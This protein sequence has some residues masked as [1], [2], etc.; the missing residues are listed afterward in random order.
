MAVPQKG[1]LVNF[2]RLL[3][4]VFVVGV[5]ATVVF[6]AYDLF[7]GP[8]RIDLA[9]K[10]LADIIESGLIVP[11][12]AIGL[13]LIFAVFGMIPFVRQA[14]PDEIKGGV[15]ATATI[16]ELWDTG[17][18]WNKNPQVGFLLEVYPQEGTPFQ[19]KTKQVVS[20]LN[21]GHIGPGG[22]V[23]VKYDP[24]KPQRLKILQFS[25]H[26]STAQAPAANHSAARLTELSELLAQGLITENEFNQ[27]RQEILRNL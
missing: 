8:G 11:L 12:L 20:R 16:V 27:K 18:T 25:G 5:W 2:S 21:V 14:L 13:A 1:D 22:Q 3:T 26:T 4:L 7:W 9:G 23:E 6:I 10:S 17:V 24:Q 15:I 19:A